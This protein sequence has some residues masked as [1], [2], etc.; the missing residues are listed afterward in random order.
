MPDI[1]LVKS[2]RKIV[3]RIN[4]DTPMLRKAVESDL[5]RLRM[6]YPEYEFFAVYGVE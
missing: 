5:E 4:A 2:I 3:F 6:E 1:E